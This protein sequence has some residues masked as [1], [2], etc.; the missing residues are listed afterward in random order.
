[1][2]Y[3]P[4][5]AIPTPPSRNSPATFTALADAFFAAFPQMRADMNALADYMEDI[6]TLADGGTFF[7]QSSATDRGANKVLLPNAF[8]L[9]S[10]SL[11]QSRHEVAN[12]DNE[13]LPQG[14]Y[15][16][17]SDGAGTKPA[18]ATAVGTLVV[19]PYA[20]P[21]E[22]GATQIMQFYYPRRAENEFYYRQNRGG[23]WSVWQ[24]VLDRSQ[25]LGAVSQSAGVPTGAVIERGS[26]SN[27]DFV[28]FADGTQ[29][30]YR[31]VTGVNSNIATGQVFTS[32]AAS[33]DFPSSF[34]SG[35]VVFGGATA[36][37]ASAL[38][39]GR[40]VGT[41]NWSYSLTSPL[42]R[43]GDA[44]SLIAIGRWF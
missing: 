37:T 12:I 33:A 4:I 17:A 8:G 5:S 34:A 23:V 25:L 38:A 36:K 21:L 32:S 44:V 2:P 29:I 7:P 24:R 43:T 35:T 10:A 22:G 39:N 11:A 41:S 18:G 13:S 20:T 27:G 14:S 26:N 30:C 28:R 6:A 40:I 15:S 9:G 19:Y 31:D 1:M 3:P 16:V 42:S